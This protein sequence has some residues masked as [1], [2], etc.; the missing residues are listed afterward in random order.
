MEISAA[1]W[2]LVAREGLFLD[3]LRLCFGRLCGLIYVIIVIFEG[4]ENKC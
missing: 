2:A 1:L 4:H 3:E